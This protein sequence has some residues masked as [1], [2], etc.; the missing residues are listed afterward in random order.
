MCVALRSL[1]HFDVNF[2]CK[3]RLK[4]RSII[5]SS[6]TYGDPPI[7]RKMNTYI[8]G[9]NVS[10]F[11]PV[12]LS[13]GGSFIKKIKS[14]TR[15]WRSCTTLKNISKKIKNIQVAMLVAMSEEQQLTIA[16]RV[17]P[18]RKQSTDVCTSDRQDPEGFGSRTS[19]A[20]IVPL[21]I[22]HCHFSLV[23]M[24]MGGIPTAFKISLS[25]GHFY[26]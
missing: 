24:G 15:I 18:T 21:H 23:C 17:W 16:F 7:Q 4:Y 14:R 12:G 1:F 13:A 8:V 5:Q 10:L 3:V 25:D 11:L 20:T 2:L 26:V 19:L 9:R 22:C 6:S